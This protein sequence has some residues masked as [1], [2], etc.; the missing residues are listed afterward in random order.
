MARPFAMA[1]VRL[2]LAGA[3][4]VMATVMPLVRAVI[5]PAVSGG[6]LLGAV[7]GD[8]WWRYVPPNGTAQRRVGG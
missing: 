8:V 6:A 2:G 1:E 5:V 3:G 7:A 4:V